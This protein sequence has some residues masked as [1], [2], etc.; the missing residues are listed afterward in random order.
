[1]H[2]NYKYTPLLQNIHDVYVDAFK[3]SCTGISGFPIVG[4]GV[5]K[6]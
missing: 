1:M 5:P 2:Q 4:V 6:C 3:A